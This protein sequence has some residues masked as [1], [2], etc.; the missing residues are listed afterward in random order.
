[1]NGVRITC[2]NCGRI[3]GDTN[4]SID[5]VINCNGCKQRA[6]IQ[7]KIVHFEDYFKD[8]NEEKENGDNESLPLGQ[9]NASH[10][11]FSAYHSEGSDSR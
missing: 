6:H 8:L 11:Q 3:L 7:M 9:H 5:A 2:P 10:D 1:M 4:Q